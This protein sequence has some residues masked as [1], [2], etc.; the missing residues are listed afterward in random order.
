M[1]RS[2]SISKNIFFRILLFFT[3]I[4]FSFL[5]L[6]GVTSAQWQEMARD[7]LTSPR[8]ETVKLEPR[9]GVPG[10]KS[11]TGAMIRSA[12]VPG[13]GQFYTEHYVKSGLIFCIESGLVISALVQDKKARDAYAV[14]YEEYLD[15]LDRRNGYLWWTAGV[16]VFSMID[17]YVD[18]HLFGFDE[19]RSSLKIRSSFEDSEC[20]LTFSFDL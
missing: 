8:G 3:R 10:T 9:K 12:V 14:D 2:F 1:Y 13:W 18:A 15:R 4:V 7:T 5:L 20:K 16:I 19:D 17:A 6:F 11:P